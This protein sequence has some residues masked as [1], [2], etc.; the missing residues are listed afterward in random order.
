MPT[1]PA[2][3][4]IKADPAGAS[5]PTK[6]LREKILQVYRTTGDYSMGPNFQQVLHALN[7]LNVTITMQQLKHEV[8]YLSGEGQLYTTIDEEHYKLTE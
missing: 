1:G 2:I 5:N 4:Q 3:H 8:D 6:S 7:Q